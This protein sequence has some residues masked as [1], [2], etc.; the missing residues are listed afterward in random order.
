MVF[1]P[2]NAK[3]V[4]ERI[5]LPCGQC[6]GCRLEKS[7]Q[8]AMR[9]MHEAS[10]YT[11]NCFLTLTFNPEHLP[12]DLSIR[13][14]HVQKFMKRLRKEFKDIKI[15]YFACGEYGEENFRPHY[16]FILFNLDFMDKELFSIQKDGHRLYTSKTVEKLWSDPKTKETY[17]F[18]VIGD[19]SFDSA[20]YVARYVMKKQTGKKLGSKKQYSRVSEETGE[21]FTVQ[22]E[23]VW[24][25][26]KPG[27]G[28]DWYEIY[29]KNAH[30][31]DFITMN[32]VK[33]KPPSFYDKLLEKV[34]E[35]RLEEIKEARV[36]YA[37]KYIPDNFGKRLEVRDKIQQRRIAQ[38]KR[39]I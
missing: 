10:L 7:R 1:D 38:L 36:E 26:L 4:N 37:K 35:K 31:K 8:W 17:G 6:H 2:S 3:N 28:T 24:M 14:E 27:I 12:K 25:S 23:Q 16:H 20:A 18:N 15:R 11:D 34:D 13:K 19:V 39:Q 9:I 22:P 5:D 32:G 29:G 33:M 30:E 21:I